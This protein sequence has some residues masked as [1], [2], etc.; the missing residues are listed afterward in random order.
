MSFRLNRGDRPDL[1]H[2][3]TRAVADAVG[4]ASAT[5]C[6]PCNCR[7]ATQFRCRRRWSRRRTSA[8]KQDG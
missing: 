4:A 1:S 8:G 5:G 3:R 6:A 7:E 2:Y